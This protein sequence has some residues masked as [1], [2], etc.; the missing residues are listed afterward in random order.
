MSGPDRISFSTAR[1]IK[2]KFLKIIEQ[3]ECNLTVHSDWVLKFQVLKSH[4]R[5]KYT[6]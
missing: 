1:P 5:T 2:E 3:F 4:V 6:T